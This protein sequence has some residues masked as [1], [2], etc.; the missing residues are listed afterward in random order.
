MN[1]C[2]VGSNSME[3]LA[4]SC[5]RVNI[6]LVDAGSTD[7]CQR[8][9][10]ALPPEFAAPSSPR[11][12]TV[13][14]VVTSAILPGRAGQPEYRI[15]RDGI[16]V[17]AEQTQEGVFQWLRRDIDCTVAQC[18]PEMLFVHGG[19]VGWR[20]LAIVIPGRS[21]SGKSTLVAE[22][23]RRGAVYYSDEFAVLD[24]T[25]RVHPY[26]RTPVLRDDGRRP[27]EL[28]LVREDEPTEPLPIGLILDGAY[29]TGVTWRPSVVSGMRAVLP[30]IDSTVLARRETSR[31]LRIAARVASTAVTLRGLRSEATDVAAQILDLVDDAL[32][33]RAFG[34]DETGSSDLTAD[35]RRVATLRLQSRTGRPDPTE[36]R[37]A[38]ARYIRMMD[39][40]SPAEHQQLLEHALA[41]QADFQDSGIVGR[42]G[43]GTLNYGVRRSRTLGRAR[44]EEIWSIF[45]HRLH[46]ILPG[47]RRE[48]G[49]P[50][51]QLGE[52]ERQL[53]AHGS[54]GFFAPHVDTGHPIAAKRR[55]SCVYYFY[56]TPRRFS[57]G[58]LRIYDTWVTPSGSTAAA[59]Y[60]TLTPVDNSIV[61]FPS[62]KFHE[63]CPVR[64]ETDA[65][66]SSRFTMTIWF[67]EGPR[68]RDRP[69]KTQ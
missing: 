68:P 8:L 58:E 17:R 65:F 50:W 37:L 24:E 9:R 52:V 4:F 47:V 41:C 45:E 20:G 12:T 56:A 53:T 67:R 6:R 2:D 46:G 5:Y 61:F 13:S 35:L 62:D 38:V 33:S 43:E 26:R 31:M 54:D 64:C 36:R 48:L 23:V 25:G 57:G 49:T 55:I 21:H 60:T 27:Q 34:A 40:L 39:F 14:Y 44:V 16:D 10:D 63:V 1:R 66:G 28:R 15:A 7:I 42:Q 29:R 18:S 22:L 19:V 69:V 51:F 11:L 3:E 59:T 32:V 30:L